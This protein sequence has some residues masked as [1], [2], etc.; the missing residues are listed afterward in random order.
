M[1]SSLAV[2]AQRKCS[3]SSLAPRIL[4]IVE[5]N[6]LQDITALLAWLPV[7][8]ALRTTSSLCQARDSASDVSR[9]RRQQGKELPARMT[10]NQLSV[11]KICVRMEESVCLSST[12]PS[13]IVLLASLVS[14][15]R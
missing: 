13:V 4:R 12:D 10:A 8:P 6:V 5:R 9:E 15:V 1:D 3:P 2:N 14:I 7:H 11:A